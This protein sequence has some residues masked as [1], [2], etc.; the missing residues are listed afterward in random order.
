MLWPKELNAPLEVVDPE[1]AD[2][3]ELEKARQWKVYITFQRR[4]YV[5]CLHNYWHNELQERK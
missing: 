4:V 1:I 3:I 5:I 2:I